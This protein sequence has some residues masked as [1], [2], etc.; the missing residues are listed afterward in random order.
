MRVMSMIHPL[1]ILLAGALT[2]NLSEVFGAS[3]RPMELASPNEEIFGS[4]GESLSFIPDVNGDGRDDVIVGA[5]KEDPGD[6]PNDAGRV[7]IFDGMN[8]DL[9]QTLVSPN[10][11]ASGQFGCSVN[12]ICDVNGDGR[13]DLVIGARNESPGQSPD[14]AGRAYLFDGATGSFLR[15]LVSPNQELSG[16]FGN[17]ISVISNIDGQCDVIVSAKDESPHGSPDGAGRVYLF[18]GFTGGMITTLLSPNEQEN[19]QFGCAVSGIEDVNGDRRGDVIVGALNETPEG[20]L[21][22]SGRAYI[23]DG[24]TGLLLQEL[25]S[26]NEEQGGAF[27]SSVSGVPD[28]NGDGYGEVVVG[29]K[30]DRSGPQLERTGRAY[31]FD[32]SNGELL[33]NL[34][35]PHGLETGWFGSSVSGVPDVNGDGSGDVVVGAYREGLPFYPESSGLAYVFNGADGSLLENLISPNRHEFGRFGSSVS[36]TRDTNNDGLGEVIVGALSE[37]PASSPLSSGRAYIF[38][39]PFEI[40]VEQTPTPTPTFTPTFSLPRIRESLR[41][42]PPKYGDPEIRKSAITTW[43]GYLGTEGSCTDPSITNFYREMIG[44]VSGELDLPTPTG[45]R[46]WSMYNHGFIVKTSD[47]T[48][49]FD[50]TSGTHSLYSVIPDEVL[51]RIDILFTSHSH[52]DHFDFS[53]LSAVKDF[54]GWVVVPEGFM[55]WP[56]GNIYLDHLDEIDIGGFHVQAFDGPHG[57]PI[58]KIYRV[59][60]SQGFTVMHDGDNDTGSALP[61]DVPVDVLLKRYWGGD[62]PVIN[63]VR[64]QLTI[65][66]HLGEIGHWCPGPRT[67]AVGFSRVF[68]LETCV[69]YGEVSVQLYGERYDYEVEREPDTPTPTATPIETATSTPTETESCP[70]PDL[71]KDSIVDAS[72]LIMCLEA[73]ES[74]VEPPPA[75]FNCDGVMDALDLFVFQDSWHEITGPGAHVGSYVITTQEEADYLEGIKKIDGSLTIGPSDENLDLTPLGSLLEITGDFWILENT[76]MTALDGLQNLQTVG[77]SLWINENTVLSSLTSLSGLKSIGTNIRTEGAVGLHIQGNDSL[78]SLDGLQSLVTIK[79]GGLRVAENDSL[80]SLDGLQSLNRLLYGHISISGNRSLASLEGLDHLTTL[81]YCSLTVLGNPLITSFDGLKNL[82][83]IGSLSIESN[84]GLVSLDGLENLNYIGNIGYFW[85]LYIYD[86]PNLASI[87]AL[88]GLTEL[89][90]GFHIENNESLAS[91]HGLEGLNVVEGSHIAIY[92]NDSLTS[93]RGLDGLTQFV[94]THGAST[95]VWVEGNDSLT[96]LDGLDSLVSVE[97]WFFEIS[98]NASLTDIGA[99]SNLVHS[100]TYSIISDNPLLD[101]YSFDL[102]FWVDGS[103][104]NLVNCTNGLCP[105]PMVL[106]TQEQ[107]DSLEG[108]IGIAGHL[109]IGPSNTDLDLTPLRTLETIKGRLL[110]RDNEALSSLDGL[111]GIT[112]VPEECSIYGNGTL[113]NLDGLQ[114]LSEVGS[115]LS[116]TDNLN[117]TS[118]TGLQ[119]LTSVGGNV[120][121]RNNV[122][123]TDI[124]ALENLI[125]MGVWT[126]ISDNASFDCSSFAF[127]HFS[128]DQS[129]GN[130]VDCPTD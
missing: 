72:D 112:R 60:T 62:C 33:Q 94:A 49:A 55:D 76:T 120:F 10:E 71:Y 36:G 39:S 128:V 104:G 87:S 5:P 34:V 29:A 84:E 86:N 6:S 31:I 80:T 57:D 51:E 12:G 105:G 103:S 113:V 11:E 47:G 25:S 59:T 32:G 7:Y 88:Q 1:I 53:I 117:L 28:V 24:S 122:A 58:N 109:T 16:H 66:G 30:Y 96:S 56:P 20:G 106:T 50:L 69:L 75:D 2:L 92:D 38:Q 19:G 22:F 9:L 82:R 116:V 23:F 107:V 21:P 70:S 77:K 14:G 126:N 61:N 17:S 44:F 54:G 108:C 100:A 97:G 40:V 43:N 90:D 4:L 67:M 124:G 46:I 41:A 65:P 3:P 74:K 73:W 111:Q 121:I 13:G 52:G 110:I 118:L 115:S 48:I 27:G 127:P 102:P 15:E 93:L 37:N 78:V 35:S 85:A 81:P 26:P 18:D 79:Y 130:L 125:N 63:R 114:G 91:L 45:M 64:P 123:L 8:G 101:C 129:T 95:G 42:N 68:A 89:G 99:L 83:E 98:N 119:N